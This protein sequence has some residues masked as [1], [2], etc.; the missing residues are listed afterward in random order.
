MIRAVQSGAH[1]ETF[2]RVRSERARMTVQERVIQAFSEHRAEIY[3]YALSLGLDFGRAQ[4][5]T[6]DAFLRLYVALDSGEPIENQRAWL[7]RVTHNLV[8]NVRLKDDRVAPWPEG[9]EDRLTDPGADP[10]RSLLETEKMRRFHEVVQGL[11][12]QQRK[13]LRLRAEGFRYREIA[14]IT[15]IKTSTVSEFLRR[16]ISRLRKARYE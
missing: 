12:E 15:G 3:R 7:F 5:L 8:L 14:E 4:E 6:Q 1:V 16:A 13:C 2:L 10:E 9:L 11:S